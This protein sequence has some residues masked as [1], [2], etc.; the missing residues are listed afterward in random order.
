MPNYLFIKGDYGYS[1]GKPTATAKDNGDGTATVTV[2]GVAGAGKVILSWGVTSTADT[3]VVDITQTGE[4]V[5]PAYNSNTTVYFKAKAF[6]AGGAESEWS[7]IGNVA[8]VIEKTA[9]PVADP[10]AGAVE[11]GTEVALT[12]ASGATI[13]YTVDGNTPD[14]DSDVYEGPIEIADAVIIK[15]I[16]Y[17]PGYKP[18]SV[19]TAAYTI[20]KVATP[21]ADPE[22]GEYAEPQTVALTCATAGAEIHYTTNGDAPTSSSTKYTEPIS[23]ETTTTIKAIAVKTGRTDSEVLT[24]EYTITT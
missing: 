14:D 10:A 3:A 18:S 11:P 21:V 6:S 22:A 12:A 17:K 8:I 16:A 13:Y 5:S 1:P 24:A 4:F 23:V 20:A 2:P 19:L 15:A 7:T 9:T